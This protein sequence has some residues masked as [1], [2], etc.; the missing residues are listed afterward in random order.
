MSSDHIEIIEALEDISGKE[1]TLDNFLS[2]MK[3]ILPN[4][5]SRDFTPAE[6]SDGYDQLLLNLNSE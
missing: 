2:F 6:L 1:M 3:E 4:G 5:Y